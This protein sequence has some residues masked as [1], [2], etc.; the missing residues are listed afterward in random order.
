MK[1]SD[2]EIKMIENIEERINFFRKEPNTDTEDF[3]I[4]CIES[5]IF[6]I[7]NPGD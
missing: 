7:K 4:D 1:L 6:I 3:L 5:L 2:K